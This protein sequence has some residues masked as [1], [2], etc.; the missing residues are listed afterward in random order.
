MQSVTIGLAFALFYVW[1]ERQ[2]RWSLFA[3]AAAGD[4]VVKGARSK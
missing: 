4:Y 3:Q 2:G 1:M